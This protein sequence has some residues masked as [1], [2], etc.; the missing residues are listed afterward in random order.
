MRYVRLMALSRAPH[1]GIIL[2]GA[3]AVAAA[4]F[5]VFN[6]RWLEQRQLLETGGIA[7]VAH[8][9]AVTIS[10]KACNSSVVLSWVDA[11]GSPH[12]GDFLSCF[13]N[14]SAGTTIPIRYLKTD[15]A[16]AMIAAGEGGLSD[17]HYKNGAL[18][19]A[20]VALIM[21]FVTAKLTVERSR[22]TSDR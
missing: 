5:G 13:A 16:T 4:V 8:I 10:H 3:M 6:W 15:P 12:S 1:A 2:V 20:V 9:D 17:D 21:A 19:G 7:A 14:R 11:S 18:I 22:K